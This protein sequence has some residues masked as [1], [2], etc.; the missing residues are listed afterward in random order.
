MGGQEWNKKCHLWPSHIL[1]LSFLSVW[2][3]GCTWLEAWPFWDMKI[4]CPV[5]CV[6]WTVLMFL[7][8]G[9]SKVS[10]SLVAA[11]I[12]VK[13]LGSTGAHTYS[14]AGSPKEGKQG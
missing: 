5:G 7:P 6:N 9:Q 14:V 8:G 11:A 2:R 12:T 1:C 10:L 3:K 4:M 13:Y